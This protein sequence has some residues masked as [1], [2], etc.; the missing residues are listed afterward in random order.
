[1]SDLYNSKYIIGLTGGIGS[2]KTTVSE[3]FKELGIDIIDADAVSRL[4][5]KAGSPNLKKIETHFGLSIL[6][7]NGELN[8]AALRKRIFNNI[9]EKHWLEN[10]LHPLIRKKID[11]LITASSSPYIIL[12]APL[13]LESKQYDFIARV[14]VV[15]TLPESQITRSVQRDDVSE[16]EIEKIIAA[17]MSREERLA[18]ADDVIINDQDIAHL[19]QQVLQLH[20]KYSTHQQQQSQQQ[21]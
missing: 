12:S 1:M 20:S 13:L 11:T 6:N 3:L 8:R 2:G 14:L 10:L 9:D 19:E 5:V 18:R 7:S 17:Q 15:D 4:L 16:T 21:Q